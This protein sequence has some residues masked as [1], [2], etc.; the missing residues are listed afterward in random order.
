VVKTAEQTIHQTEFFI[1]SK[2]K[3]KM[4]YENFPRPKI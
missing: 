2:N 3:N 4:S 1:P